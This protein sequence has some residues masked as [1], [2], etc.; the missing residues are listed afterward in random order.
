VHPV[1]WAKTLTP[2]TVTVRSTTDPTTRTRVA[3][4]TESRM[5]TLVKAL[6]E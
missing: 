6:P 1:K 5:M 3:T 4:A 2:A